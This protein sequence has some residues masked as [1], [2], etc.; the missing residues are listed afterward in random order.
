MNENIAVPI[1]FFIAVVVI[2]I[3]V[4]IV[5]AVIRRS[6]RQESSAGL[7][8]ALESRLDRLEAMIETVAVEVERLAEGQRFTTR[9]LSEGAIQPV[10]QRA[11]EAAPMGAAAN[12]ITHA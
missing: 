10:V 3:V 9:L 8:P 4:P 12:E 1:A 7:T 5:R 6:E 11:R 2:M